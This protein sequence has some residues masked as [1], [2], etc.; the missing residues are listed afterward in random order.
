MILAFLMRI[1]VRLVSL[2]TELEYG[3]KQWNG[4]YGIDYDT[5]VLQLCSSFFCPFP[6]YQTLNMLVMFDFE[7]RPI[8]GKRRSDYE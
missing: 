7:W 3:L 2:I 6:L 4:L 5:L 1:T 8:Q